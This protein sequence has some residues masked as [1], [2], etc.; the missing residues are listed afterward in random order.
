MA[1]FRLCT[2]VQQFFPHS[3]YTP[4]VLLCSVFPLS[5]PCDPPCFAGHLLHPLRYQGWAYT[6]PKSSREAG[7]PLDIWAPTLRVGP[8]PSPPRA[9]R[10]FLP[11]PTTT[12]FISVVHMSCFCVLPAHFPL[13]PLRVFWHLTVRVGHSTAM[14]GHRTVGTPFLSL[15]T[16]AA[17]VTTSGFTYA[18]PTA[19]NGP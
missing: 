14:C 5:F 8:P 12:Y 11:C 16:C 13:I 2:P 4:S 18:W 15:R 10:I 7:S 17:L 6:P 19:H 1:P 3:D 9:P